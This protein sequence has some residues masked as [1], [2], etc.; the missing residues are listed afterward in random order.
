MPDELTTIQ[1]DTDTRNLLRALA[2]DDFRS[3]T[4]ELKWLV[5]QEISRRRATIIISDPPAIDG[6]LSG[7]GPIE[8]GTGR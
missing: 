4:S 8:V 5:T 3:M 7:I 6:D 2:A 1:V